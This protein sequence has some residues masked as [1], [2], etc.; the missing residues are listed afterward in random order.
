LSPEILSPFTKTHSWWFDEIYLGHPT[1]DIESFIELC[2]EY[3]LLPRGV[4]QAYL[5]REW[6][7]TY[8]AAELAER[9]TESMKALILSGERRYA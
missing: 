7:K 4:G 9:A 8:S 3:S 5:R 2:T 6:V 1:D